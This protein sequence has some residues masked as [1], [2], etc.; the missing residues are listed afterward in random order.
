MKHYFTGP[1][2]YESSY[3]TPDPP[4]PL[5]EAG[6]LATLLAVIGVVT[7]EDAAASVGLAPEDLIHEAQSWAVAQELSNG[8]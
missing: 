5:G 8:N 1:Y 3:E 4:L 2:G 6:A 7:I